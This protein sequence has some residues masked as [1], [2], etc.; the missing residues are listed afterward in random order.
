MVDYKRLLSN[1]GCLVVVN[2]VSKLEKYSW[3]FGFIFCRFVVLFDFL[4]GIVLGF[5]EYLNLV[6]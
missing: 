3:V 2:I 4:I 6:V 1:K 5:L